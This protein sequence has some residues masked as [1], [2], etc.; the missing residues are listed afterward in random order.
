MN[1][2]KWLTAA[3]AV[4]VFSAGM[5]PGIASADSVTVNGTTYTCTNV[6]NLTA[7]SDG[8]ITVVDCCGGR[9]SQ[10]MESPIGD[11]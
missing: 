10:T 3:L 7:G 2:G 11:G 8:S 5:A 4:V 1:Q 6:C 9:V